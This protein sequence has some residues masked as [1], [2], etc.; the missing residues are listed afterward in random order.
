MVVV[1]MDKIKVSQMSGKM[2]NVPAI[3]TNPLSNSFCKKMN[4]SQNNNIICKNCYSYNMLKTYR[5]NCVPSFERNTNILKNKIFEEQ[6]PLFKKNNI[7]RIHA[8][9]ELINTTHLKNIFKITNKNPNQT[10]SLYTKRTDIVNHLLDNQV[11]PNNMII[12]YSNP[13]I[14][15]PIT[16]I[17]QNFDK[18]FNICKN[19]HLDKINCGAKSCNTC[20]NCYKFNGNN[21]IYEKIK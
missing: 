18:V 2:K 5:K 1:K 11:K 20:R 16:K 21:I 17:P 15:K 4:N 14:D 8:H 10:F 19:K 9:G 12:I 7:V 13:I 6:I 3:N